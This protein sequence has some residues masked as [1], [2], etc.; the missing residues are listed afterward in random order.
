M[1]VMG[2]TMSF[3]ARVSS[4][5]SVP[6]RKITPGLVNWCCSSKIIIMI[7]RILTEA[8]LPGQYCADAEVH[9]T[10]GERERERERSVDAGDGGVTSHKRPISNNNPSDPQYYYHF[11]QTLPIQGRLMAFRVGAA[12]FFF[13]FFSFLHLPFFFL[14]ATPME[15]PENGTELSGSR[16]L[17]IQE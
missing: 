7:I 4:Q 13:F 12:F 14:F 16:G 1:D 10:E 15:Q 17:D 11:S 8:V 9:T 3:I 2:K 6:F 5:P